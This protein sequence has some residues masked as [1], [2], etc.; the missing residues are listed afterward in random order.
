MQL[1]EFAAQIH[2][3]CILGAATS[4]GLQ[5]V[6]H[7]ESITI[8]IF[9]AI[10][11][12]FVDITQSQQIQIFGLHGAALQQDIAIRIQ[13]GLFRGLNSTTIVDYIIFGI[14]IDVS[15]C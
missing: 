11:I 8:G 9:R 15:A 2:T 3:I 12:G 1:V 6:A 7:I 14:Q 13:E 5:G 10:I 4:Q